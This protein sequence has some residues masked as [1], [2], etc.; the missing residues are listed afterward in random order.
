MTPAPHVVDLNAVMPGLPASEGATPARLKETVPMPG[1]TKINIK[2][3]CKVFGL[4]DGKFVAVEKFNLKIRD[5]EFISIVG[6]SG[7]GKSTILRILAGLERHTSGLV[8][9]EVNDTDA[10]QLNMVFQEASAL[11]WMTVA[12]NVAYG[13]RRRGVSAGEIEESV[14]YWLNAM[15]LTRF[16]NAYPHQL[17]GGMK[18]RV[19]IA[20][21]FAND[22]DI[23]LMDEPFAAL[24]ALTKILLQNEL[25]SLWEATRKTV[26]Y[27]THSLEEA[28]TLSDR[29]VVMAA[30]PGTVKSVL[31]IPFERPRDSV[32]LKA[33]PRYAAL[34]SDIWSQLQ[35]E[36]MKP[37]VRDAH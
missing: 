28:L 32:A 11:P 27:V 20:R 23:L 5:G 1:A 29:V 35:E 30:R 12:D 10:P 6:P 21:A 36:V 33:D 17:S 26:V 24:D 13:L 9:I 14:G 31:D 16:R 19:S 4:R 7:C 2:D 15:A 34:Y 37:Q 8:E 22:P 25:L 18:Q 3:L